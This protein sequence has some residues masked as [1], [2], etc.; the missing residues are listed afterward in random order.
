MFKQSQTKTKE[1]GECSH[2]FR[3]GRG[4]VRGHGRGHGSGEDGCDNDDNEKPRDQSRIKCYN[5]NTYG[6]YASQRRNKKKEEKANLAEM[7][8]KESSLL[9]AVTELPSTFLLQGNSGIPEPNGMWYL[10]TRVTNHM[11]VDK[12]FFHDLIEKPGGLVCF[13]DRSTV[14]IE[15]FGLVLLHQKDKKI[16]KLKTVFYVPKLVVNILSLGKFDDEGYDIRLGSR[17]LRVYDEQGALLLL[18]K[19]NES[20]LYLHKFNVVS[21]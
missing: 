9:I 14:E 17:Q 5:C 8:A 7:E 16:V 10:D 18:V 2:V 20:R 21:Q 6:H 3:E 19:K 12:S 13:G 1:E 15:G 11:T 4:H